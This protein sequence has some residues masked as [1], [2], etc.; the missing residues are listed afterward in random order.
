VKRNADIGL[1]T[2]PLKIK[3]PQAI[4]PAAFCFV[5]YVTAQQ[6]TGAPRLK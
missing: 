1:F 2:N 4:L 3:K 6:S 5:L